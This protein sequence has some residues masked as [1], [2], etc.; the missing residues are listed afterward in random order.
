MSTPYQQQ[1][2]QQVQAAEWARFRTSYP[3]PVWRQMSQPQ[4]AQAWATWQQNERL[5]RSMRRR[6]AWVWVLI[7]VGV[8]VLIAIVI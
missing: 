2:N 1:L 5:H 6:P 3:E 7:A 8:L 4:Q